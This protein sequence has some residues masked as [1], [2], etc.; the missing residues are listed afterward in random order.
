MRIHALALLTISALVA[1]GGSDE[2]AS[3]EGGGQDEINAPGGAAPGAEKPSTTDATKTPPEEQSKI[4]QTYAPHLH[5]H[6]S[7]GLKPANVDWYLARTKLRFRHGCGEHDVLALGKVNQKALAEAKHDE[8]DSAC[9]HVP[10]KALLATA[11]DGFFLEIVSE[12]TRA[13]APRADWKTYAVW[14]PQKATNLVD[15]EYWFFYPYNDGFSVFN[16]ESDWEHVRVTVNLNGKDGKHE[17]TEV[18]LSAH[19][20]GTIL[21]V[22]DA[23][24]KMEGGTHPVAYVAKGTHANYPKPGTYDIEGTFG[25][26]KD[27]AKEAAAA[28]VWKTETAIVEVGTRAAVKNDQ[29]FIKYRGFWGNVG[30]DIPETDGVRRSFP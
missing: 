15:I 13:G 22:G 26:A 29:V 27:E 19:K 6:P 8:V 16:H 9:K 7:D 3:P 2:A 5:L 30:S 12:T 28:N 23:K 18:K 11:S 4:V 14:R 17:P 24:L 21:R 10:N 25:V 20:G 1:C